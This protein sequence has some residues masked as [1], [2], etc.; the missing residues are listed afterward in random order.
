MFTYLFIYL[1]ILSIIGLVSG[2]TAHA[3]QCVRKK[4]GQ[5]CKCIKLTNSHVVL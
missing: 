4:R 5:K 3:I 2:I 1:K